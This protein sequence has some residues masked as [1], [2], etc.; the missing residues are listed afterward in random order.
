MGRRSW[1]GP[2][3]CAGVVLGLTWSVWGEAGALEEPPVGVV[4]A[5]A[6][7]PF[8]ARVAF[9]RAL[10]PAVATSTVGRTIAFDETRPTARSKPA[11]SAAEAADTR[12][13]L[14]VAAARLV[15]G[16]RTLVLTTDPHPRAGTYT[17]ELPDVRPAGRPADAPTRPLTVVYDLTG[18]EAVWD[19]GAEDA[20]PEW[21][22]WWPGF[23]PSGVREQAGDVPAIARGLDLSRR[24]GRLTLTALVVLPRGPVTLRVTSNEKVDATLGG[25]GPAAPDVSGGPVVFQTESTGEPTLLTVA[26]RSGPNPAVRVTVQVGDDPK[27]ERPLERDSLLVSWAPPAPAPPA[28][29]ENVPDLGGGD[30]RKGAVVFASAEAKCANCH[31]VR[32][33]GGDVGPDLS[34][35]A[36]R[37]RLR[38]YRDI[39]EPSVRIH[40]DYVPYTVALKD[41][42]VLVGTVRAEGADRVKVT[43]T[44]AKSTVVA[45]SEI[46]EFRPSG[47][48]IM[49]VGLAGAIGEPNLRDLIAF[50]TA[51]VAEGRR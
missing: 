46:E 11:R 40:P 45:R 3:W 25:E 7:G 22:G 6:A 29:L 12:G 8:E 51:P 39:A 23:D 10:S 24:D 26:L 36:G 41:G 14:R 9:D 27:G 50:L 15:D 31:K 49:P 16:G 1:F 30:P 18:V 2:A 38:V 35:L 44:E 47:T 19:S 5:W 21:T 48:S 4:A 17:L 20:S 43:D 42:R 32:G 33:Q 37:D 28:P 34:D 13:T